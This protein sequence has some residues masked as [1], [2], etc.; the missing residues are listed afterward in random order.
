VKFSKQLEYAGCFWAIVGTFFYMSF[1]DTANP[2]HRLLAIIFLCVAVIDIFGTI[3]F[4]KQEKIAEKRLAAFKQLK[5]DFKEQNGTKPDSP[6]EDEK[7]PD[8]A[9][10]R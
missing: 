10:H 7:S 1:L 9:D 5:K 2:T 8:D 6:A 3:H 4:A